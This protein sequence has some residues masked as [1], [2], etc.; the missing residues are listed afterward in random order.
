MSEIN[1]IVGEYDKVRR[2]TV[3]IANL[4]EEK[5]WL[6]QSMADASP[7]RWHLGH[8]SWFFDHFVLKSHVKNYRSP[9]KKYD[10]FFNSYYNLAGKMLVRNL[11]GSDITL[12]LSEMMNY[13]TMIDKKILDF[14]ASQKKIR[15]HRLKKVIIL[16]LN[17]E[18]QHQE[19]M[20]MDT[21]NLLFGKKKKISK[22]KNRKLSNQLVKNKWMNFKEGIYQIGYHG[23]KF[24]YDNELPNHKVYLKK[25]SISTKLV[26]NEE[27][28]GFIEDRGYSR[29]ELWLSD[30]WDFI[31]KNKIRCPLYWFKENGKFFRYTLYGVEHLKLKEPVSHIS[32]YEAYAY[33]RWKKKRLPLESELEIYGKKFKIEG[34]FLE[35]SLYEPSQELKDSCFGN[36]WQHTSSPYQPYPGYHHSYDAIGEYNGKFMNN[37]MVLKGGSAI[38]PKDHIRNSYRN[39]FYPHQ[40]WMYSGIRLAKH[41]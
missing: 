13:R 10:F 37:Q 9:G 15:N 40:R 19:L 8:T 14:L 16:G 20:L 29:P 32:Y 26:N 39:F 31:K 24:C 5:D 27:Y 25:F 35:D 17:H 18:Q 38:T 22:R 1:Q 11:R 7:I 41:L 23:K 3:K 36:L 21:K 33:A 2:Q 4:F 12:T 28:L 34:N 30:G 6:K